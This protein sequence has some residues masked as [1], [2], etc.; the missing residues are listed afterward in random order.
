MTCSHALAVI[1]ETLMLDKTYF[2]FLLL[3]ALTTSNLIGETSVCQYNLHTHV[4][5]Y[6][7][8][9]RPNE[10]FVFKYRILQSYHNLKLSRTVSENKKKVVCSLQL[11][12]RNLCMRK[13][14]YIR[15]IFPARTLCSF[16]SSVIETV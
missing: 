10:L 15:M 11:K 13:R 12:L 4:L 16:I 3:G 1:T 7:R 14:C 9:T 8:E 6:Y 5:L 2:W